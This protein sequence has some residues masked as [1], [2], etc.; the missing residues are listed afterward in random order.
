MNIVEARERFE[1]EAGT[2]RRFL[3]RLPE[4]KL[5][6][7]PH[8]K[9]FTAG[10]LAGHLVECIGWAESIFAAD[11][12]DFDPATYRPIEA[13]SLSGLLEVF[14]AKV[15]AGRQALAAASDGDLSRLWRMTVRGKVH[16]ERSKAAVFSD[17]TIDHVIHHRGQLS[18]YLRL[19]DVAVPGAYGPSADEG[20]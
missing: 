14:D 15:A 9:S 10:G 20:R 5:T 13:T 16:F 8:P 19:L 11:E 12:L 6:W 4:S 7:R 1:R 2:T 18:V 17:F 3:E